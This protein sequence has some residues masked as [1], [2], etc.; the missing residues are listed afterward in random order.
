MNNVKSLRKQLMAAIA[1]VLV[2]AVALGS[3]TYAWFAANKTVTADGMQVSA[4]SSSSLVIATADDAKSAGVGDRTIATFTGSAAKLIPT[5]HDLG[6]GTTSGLVYN[7]NP[8]AVSVTTGFLS[9]DAGTGVALT[10]ADPATDTT[11]GNVYYTDYVVCIASSGA[12][13]TGQDLV[14]KLDDTV[15]AAK[16]TMNA[17]SI[18]F[19]V[20]TTTTANAASEISSTTYKGTL[21]V[22]KTGIGSSGS[23]TLLTNGDI[24]KN[25]QTNSFLQ[26]TMRVYVDGALVDQSKSSAKTTA[27]VANDSVDIAEQ[28]LVVN[29]EASTTT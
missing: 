13:M 18:D 24:P 25:Q 4:T 29:F 15:T 16:Y 3:S 20:Q 23:V 5:T 10:F 7:T 21:N 27:Y 1:M 17:T 22:A 14:A 9:D 11:S 28:Q 6:N 2:A 26:V 19:Y 12:A 8:E